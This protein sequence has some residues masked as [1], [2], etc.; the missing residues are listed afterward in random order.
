[1]EPVTNKNK[2]VPPCFGRWFLHP[3]QGGTIFSFLVPGYLPGAG[4]DGRRALYVW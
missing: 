4:G 2:N 1:M 3:K